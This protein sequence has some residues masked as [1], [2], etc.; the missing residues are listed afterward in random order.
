MPL[1]MTAVPEAI[2]LAPIGGPGD[3]AAAVAVPISPTITGADGAWQ[4]PDELLAELH[5][6]PAMMTTTVAELVAPLVASLPALPDIAASIEQSV[7]GAVGTAGELIAAVPTAIA[8]PIPTTILGAESTWQAPDGLLAELFDAP[9]LEAPAMVTAPAVALPALS[10]PVASVEQSIAG[11]AADA[12]VTA[13]DAAVE[14]VPIGFAGQS[15]ADT[16]DALAGP[17]GP[18]TSLLQGIA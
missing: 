8:A 10:E 11:L 16:V 9:A 13:F 2:R 6:L 12:P 3:D 15:Y 7:A 14:L 17:F 4:P 1:R 5:D 18:H